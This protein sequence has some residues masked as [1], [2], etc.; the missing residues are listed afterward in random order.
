LVDVLNTISICQAM[1]SLLYIYL[2]LWVH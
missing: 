2:L 1:L